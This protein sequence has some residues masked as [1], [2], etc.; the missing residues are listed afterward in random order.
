MKTFAQFLLL[1]LS[2]LPFNGLAQHRNPSNKHLNFSGRNM[3]DSNFTTMP[4]GALIGADFSNATLNGAQFQNM[5]LTG[6]NFTNATMQRSE[7]SYVDLSG[8]TLDHTNFQQAKMQDVNLE[9]AEFTATDLTDAQMIGAQFGPFM[10]I[11]AS[12][13]SIRTKFVG[14]VLDMNHFPIARWPSSYWS[15]TDLS[16]C[17][18]SGFTPKT[19]SFASRNISGAKMQGND[20]SHFDFRKCIMS[21]ADLSN[22]NLSYANLSGALLFNAKLRGT[23]LVYA[24]LSDVKCYT[25]ANNSNADFTGAT[26]NN[27]ILDRGNFSAAVMSGALLRGAHADSCSFNNA[28][29]NSAGTYSVADFSGADISRSSFNKA[30]LNSVRFI[31]V[32]AIRTQFANCTM[33]T[34]DF[35]GAV[36]P[37]ASF[38]NSSLEGV[39]LTGAILQNVDFTGSSLVP[40]SGGASVD[41]SCSQLGGA[42]FTNAKVLNVNFADAVML[43]AD[44]CCQTLEGTFCGTTII[45]QRGYGATVLPKLTAPVTC[46]NGDN[47]ICQGKQWIVP[48][49]NTVHCNSQHTA[50]TVWAK[51]DC[52]GSVQDTVGTIHFPD[53]N[54][55][56]AIV[57]D[58]FN[59]D[60]TKVITDSLAAHVY[61]LNCAGYNIS[62]LEGLQYFKNLRTLNLNQNNLSNGDV[63][64]QLT[65]L[66]TLKVANNNLPSMDLRGLKNLIYLDASNNKLASLQFDA[67]SYLNFVDASYNQLSQQDFSL[68]YY[69][70][71]L[72]LSYNKLTTVG[73]LSQL[74]VLTAIFLENNSLTKIGN[75]AAIYD[76][77]NANLTF[78][79]LACNAKFDCST[80]G[81]TDPSGQQ[82]LNS[83]QC[84]KTDPGCNTNVKPLS[85]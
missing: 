85:R 18:I 25:G 83:S 76:D 38:N 48:N 57:H 6:A 42:D 68:Q 79:N 49:W 69:L 37:Q 61:T 36:M 46:P 67:D 74:K 72:D 56:A 50:Q 64:R 14:T 71:Y 5:D 3:T 4:Q 82:L 39:L 81:L 19:F 8:T 29:F 43:P 28:F 47:A 40:D 31:N 17:K 34:T 23:R 20:F 1:T 55:K 65:Q 30:S 10:S 12:P 21:S 44:S 78:L 70:N 75:L 33:Q 7:K 9:Y 77:G 24:N 73:D 63:F 84:G 41:L 16:R 59:G 66:A 52:G 53:P 13:D 62:N 11:N 32:F 22:S 54:L 51:P 60:N 27:A 58:L 80:L 26:M 35:T 2:A 15:C 45:N